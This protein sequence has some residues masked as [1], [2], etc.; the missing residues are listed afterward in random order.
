MPAL[1]GYPCFWH[2]VEEDDTNAFR[3]CGECFHV[4]PTRADLIQAHLTLLLE[5]RIP[6]DRLDVDS[7]VISY[8]PMCAHDF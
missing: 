7:L 3:V 4:F 1:H 8:C 6:H 2:E 5:C